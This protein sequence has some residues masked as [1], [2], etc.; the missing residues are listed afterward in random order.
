MEFLTILGLLVGVILFIVALKLVTRSSGRRA[1]NRRMEVTSNRSFL[2]KLDN[3]AVEVY[4]YF[5]GGGPRKAENIR[6]EL[7]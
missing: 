7:G 4:H 3:I 1:I 6:L 2:L 5:F